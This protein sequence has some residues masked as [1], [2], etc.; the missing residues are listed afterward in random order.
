MNEVPVEEANYVFI[1]GEDDSNDDSVY[2]FEDTGAYDGSFAYD[3]GILTTIATDGSDVFVGDFSSDEIRRY[4]ADGTSLG[5]FVDTSGM[6]GS[7]AS[8]NHIE[9]DAAGDLYATPAGFSSNPRTSRR[10]DAS[11][12]STGTFSHADLVFPGGIDADADGN[13]YIVNSAA[14][15]VGNKLFKF[16]SSGTYLGMYDITQVSDPF[17]MAIDEA[18]EILYIGD[19]YGG[20]SG[21]KAYDIS[22]ATPTFLNSVSTPGLNGVTGISF[23]PASGHLFAADSDGAIEITTSGTLVNSYSGGTLDRADDIVRLPAPVLGDLDGDRFVGSSD[24]DIVRAHWGMTITPGALRLGDPSGDGLVGS[25]DLDIVRANWGQTAAA[26]GVA[27]SGS[28]DAPKVSTSTGVPSLISAERSIPPTDT[29]P[30]DAYFAQYRSGLAETAWAEAVEALR[31]RRE[32]REE[33]LV[34][35]VHGALME[36]G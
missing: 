22:G 26:A 8:L 24:L 5:V 7:G 9:F 29:Q 17:D 25:A 20:A 33:R 30:R 35:A 12:T 28:E 27:P 32:K 18:G 34:S 15:G 14:V 1:V 3:S 23:D 2:R 6:L 31:A 19:F 16:S 36:W 4:S 10:F 13:V 11:G 21:I